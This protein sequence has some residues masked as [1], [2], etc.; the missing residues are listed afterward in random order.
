MSETQPPAGSIKAGRANLFKELTCDKRISSS[1]F[2][3]WH[4]LYPFASKETSECFPGVRTLSEMTGLAQGYHTKLTKE[5]KAASWLDFNNG[6]NGQRRYYVLL[7]GKGGR[8]F[9]GDHEPF[10][11]V[12]ASE[13][14]DRSPERTEPFTPV[15]EPFTPVNII[16][17]PSSKRGVIKKKKS[18]QGQVTPVSTPA[19][20][21]LPAGSLDAA[22]GAAGAPALEEKANHDP[23]RTGLPSFCNSGEDQ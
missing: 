10:T 20:G 13:N 8:F 16:K 22:P 5:L 17:T 23:R 12:N 21:S 19:L 11:P 18:P 9:G 2:R 4:A 14:G 15:N 1:A 3:L 6:K 7:N